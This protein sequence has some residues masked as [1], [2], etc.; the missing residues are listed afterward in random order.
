MGAT[1]PEAGSEVD[2]ANYMSWI[3][4]HGDCETPIAVPREQARHRRSKTPHTPVKLEW[5]AAYCFE[6]VAAVRAAISIF[7]FTRDKSAPFCL[8]SFTT[9]ANSPRLCFAPPRAPCA[10]HPTT[11]HALISVATTL[12]CPGMLLLPR[13]AYPSRAWG[14]NGRAVE[15]A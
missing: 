7:I 6:P 8:G 3:G 12:L 11:E 9:T 13:L 10:L 2:F 4:D 15:A 5:P 1:D 14:G